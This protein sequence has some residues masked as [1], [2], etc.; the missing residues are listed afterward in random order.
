MST[1]AFGDDTGST[2]VYSV[3]CTGN[4]P[5]LLNCSH[6]T[7]A[8]ATCSHSAAV[9]CQGTYM[10]ILVKQGVSIIIL[11]GSVFASPVLLLVLLLSSVCTALFTATKF[12]TITTHFFRCGY[13]V[14]QLQ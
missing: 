8:S 13:R 1:G 2:I 5:E 14:L 7:T 4:E 12:H 9:I 6:S 11:Y 3:M 10:C